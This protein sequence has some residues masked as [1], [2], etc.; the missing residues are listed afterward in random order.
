[1][2]A[3]QLNRRITI[4]Q[5]SQT[6]DV[7]GQPTADWSDLFTT[8]GGIRAATGKEVYA[9]SGFTSQVSHVITLRYRPR[10]P[11]LNSYRVLYEGRIFRIQAVS[12]PDEGREQLNLLCLE[13]DEG[14]R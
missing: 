14:V 1:M 10:T 6:R 9:A 11:I 7:Y 4:Q 13:L 5:R 3:A 8:W 12:D 2:N